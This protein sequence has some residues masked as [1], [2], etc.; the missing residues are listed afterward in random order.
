MVERALYAGRYVSWGHLPIPGSRN[1]Y[2]PESSHDLGDV[3][4][5]RKVPPTQCAQR[6]R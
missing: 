2:T 1:Q 6:G 4:A 3:E 5:D